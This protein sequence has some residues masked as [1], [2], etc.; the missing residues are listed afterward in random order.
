MTLLSTTNL[1]F[2]NLEIDQQETMGLEILQSCI[3]KI[4]N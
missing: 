1:E 2:E 3:K 4:K